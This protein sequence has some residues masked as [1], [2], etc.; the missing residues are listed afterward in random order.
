M[1]GKRGE[2]FEAAPM[3]EI[4]QE[5]P[6]ESKK[7]E[8]PD[9]ATAFDRSRAQVMAKERERLAGEYTV[10]RGA[11]TELRAKGENDPT[12]KAEYE[13]VRREFLREV[14]EL[15]VRGDLRLSKTVNE[16]GLA[17]YMKGGK[18]EKDG[19]PLSVFELGMEEIVEQVADVASINQ[20]FDMLI[21]HRPE[22]AEALVFIEKLM[23]ESIAAV[24]KS[25]LQKKTQLSREANVPTSKAEAAR[26]EQEGKRQLREAFDDIAHMVRVDKERQKRLPPRERPHGTRK[27]G[28][29]GRIKGM[30]GGGRKA[31]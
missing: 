7:E 13:R 20:R 15:H 8:A 22:G 31:G 23:P 2:R 5:R 1:E 27:P 28:L 12:A 4:P 29:I 14:T 26:I 17:R 11:L 21:E 6:V 3:P 16:A 25:L 30:F 9:S 10:L 19:R 24:E 18:H